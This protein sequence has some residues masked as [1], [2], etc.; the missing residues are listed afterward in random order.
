MTATAD[1]GDAIPNPGPICI[2]AAVRHAHTE[3]GS[4]AAQFVHHNM[5]PL[6]DVDTAQQL[7]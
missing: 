4:E 2:A 5:S 7:R 1:A 6:T 3:P